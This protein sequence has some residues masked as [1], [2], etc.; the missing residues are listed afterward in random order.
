VTVDVPRE[1]ASDLIL[2]AHAGKPKGS[3]RTFAT[4]LRRSFL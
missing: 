4:A 3:P 2:G 1:R